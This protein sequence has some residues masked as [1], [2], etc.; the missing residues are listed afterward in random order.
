MS[1]SV[2]IDVAAA[3]AA[4]RGTVYLVGAGPGDPGLLTLRA[5]AL[6]RSCDVVFHD[7][8]ASPAVLAS[9]T[10]HAIKVDVGKVGH[11]A[12]ADQDEI[13]ASLVRAA[14]AGLRVV[15]LK[16]G[17]PFVFGRGAEE[18]LALAAAGVPFEVVP[19]V[20]AMS[21]VPA[22]AGIPLTHR[23]LA[24]SIGVIAGACAGDG[25]LPEAIGGA[26]SADTVVA[27][28][29]LANLA[30]LVEDLIEAGRNADT[31]AAAIAAGTTGAQRTV[32][33]T[34][35]ELTA[36]V[37]AAELYAPVLVVVGEVVTLQ[38]RLA[39]RHAPAAAPAVKGAVLP[40]V[41]I[42]WP[43]AGEATTAM[44]AHTE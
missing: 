1:E 38:A 7:R 16:G 15:R 17:D 25:R 34:L 4:R 19:G 20:S 9:V 11:G 22:S 24:T 21:A 43:P 29:A 8:L 40:A 37:R 44:R 18:A 31:P 5:A 12:S 35:A 2:D 6:L 14:R 32:V 42:A 13:S 26:A 30:G 10:A 36:D 23:G 28:M 41:P 33:S 27:F 3:S 39:P